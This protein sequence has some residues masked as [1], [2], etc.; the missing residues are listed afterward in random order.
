M[1]IS[2]NKRAGRHSVLKGAPLMYFWHLAEERKH[3]G[4]RRNHAHINHLASG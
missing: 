1:R 4:Q 2:S 3:A